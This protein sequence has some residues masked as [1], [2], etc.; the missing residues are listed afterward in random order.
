MP[1]WKKMGKMGGRVDMRSV[2]VGGFGSGKVN[3][4]GSQVEVRL[5]IVLNS[6]ARSNV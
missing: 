4:L 3:Y 6:I 1:G 2:D 5:T